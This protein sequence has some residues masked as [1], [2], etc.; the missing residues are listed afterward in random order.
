MISS[1]V[2]VTKTLTTTEV[3]LSEWVM[4]YVVALPSPKVWE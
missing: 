3:L 2:E 1:P 4:A